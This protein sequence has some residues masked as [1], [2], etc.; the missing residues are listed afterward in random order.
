MSVTDCCVEKYLESNRVY[1]VE[2]CCCLEAEVGKL[3]NQIEQLLKERGKYACQVAGE[4]RNEVDARPESPDDRCL[5]PKSNQQQTFRL[6]IGD[7]C[8]TVNVVDHLAH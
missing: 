4:C 1:W 7:R 6:L 3:R 2:K 5:T 8:L